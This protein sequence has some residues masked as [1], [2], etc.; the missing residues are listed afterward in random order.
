MNIEQAEYLLRTN[1]STST[2]REA[3]RLLFD[4]LD[5]QRQLIEV[6]ASTLREY[7]AASA[8]AVTTAWP[9]NLWSRLFVLLTPL[10]KETQ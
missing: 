4:E 7:R 3:A 10:N 9:S 6:L 5:Q 8:L 1:S 2:H